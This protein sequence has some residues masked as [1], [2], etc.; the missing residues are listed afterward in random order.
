MASRRE[1]KRDI[2][3]LMQDLAME[4][5]VVYMVNKQVKEGDLE[6]FLQQI[7]IVEN[8]F[9]KRVNHPNGTTE[10]KMV[11]AYYNQ[12]KK[13]FE[14]KYMEIVKELEKAGK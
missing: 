13:D 6:K 2:H 14:A 11:A 5:Y 9:L 10:R 12:L 3:L 8:E 4:S 1:L 7:S